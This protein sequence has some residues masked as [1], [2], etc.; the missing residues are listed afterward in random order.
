MRYKEKREGKDGMKKEKIA[1]IVLAAG[2][3]SRMKSDIQKQYM[4]LAGKPVVAHSLEQFEKS[5]VDEVILVTGEDEIE[6]CR[7]NIVEAYHFTKV[8]KIV[9]GGSERY[10]SV[11][12]ALEAMEDCDYVLI[13]DGARP[14]ITQKIIKDCIE[15]VREHGVCI[16]GMPVKDTIKIVDEETFAK[17][18]PN[19]SSLWQVQT[20]QCFIYDEIKLA[21]EKMMASNAKNITDDAMVMEQFGDRKVKLVQGSYENIKITTPEDMEI[22]E[23]FLKRIYSR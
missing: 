1:A 9:A 2:K 15:N 6:Y 12:H 14:C 22:G 5:D 16:I 4:T 10:E 20:P 23:V 7:E 17:N 13:H 8:K 3:G 21:Y 11:Y 18:T 19:R